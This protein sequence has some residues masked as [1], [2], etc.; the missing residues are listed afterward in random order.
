MEVVGAFGF[1]AAPDPP[2]ETDFLK[3]RNLM[4]TYCAS[5]YGT[6]LLTGQCLTKALFAEQMLARCDHR[7]VMR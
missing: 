5:I 1:H 2:N 3:N 6:E 7:N 4:T